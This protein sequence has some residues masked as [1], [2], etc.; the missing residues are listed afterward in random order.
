MAETDKIY[1]SS[2]PFQFPIGYILMSATNINPSTFLG[3]GT[4]ELI[5]NG[6]TILGASEDDEGE[7]T[8]GSMSKTLVAS[9][10]PGHTHS[11]SGHT[12]QVPAHNHTASSSS[13]GSHSHGASTSSAGQHGHENS[14]GTSGNHR[15]NVF[16]SA[17]RVSDAHSHSRGD[18]SYNGTYVQEATNYNN[19]LNSF[20]GEWPYVMKE[21]GAH[22]H[23]LSI[24]ANGSHTHSLTINNGGSHSHTI[25]VAN[26]AAFN[27]GSGG[28]GN[29]GSTGSG[30]SFDITPSYIKLFIWKRIE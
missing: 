9:N 17:L 12:H 8:G 30:T 6:R 26:K 24:Y 2:I 3:Y 15:H 13:A 14:V 25:T 22:N 28:S 18:W 4:W 16:L 1:F 19:L 21:A 5:G 11:I 20:D 27:T 10:I 7:E 23:S 29:T